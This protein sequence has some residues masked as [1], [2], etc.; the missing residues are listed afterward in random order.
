MHL[1]TFESETGCGIDEEEP[2]CLFH[3]EGCARGDGQ[4]R[5]QRVFD[6]RSQVV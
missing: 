3:S 5:P 2:W 6:A 4:D 1:N